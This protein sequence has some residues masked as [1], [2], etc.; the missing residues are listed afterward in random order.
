MDFGEHGRTWEMED[1]VG[2]IPWNKTRMWWS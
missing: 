2:K 1:K